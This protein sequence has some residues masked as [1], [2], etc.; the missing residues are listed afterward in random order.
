MNTKDPKSSKTPTAKTPA[1]MLED[2]VYSPTLAGNNRAL[3]GTNPL[4]AVPLT[5]MTYSAVSLL[6]LF[7]ATKTEAGKKVLEKTVSLILDDAEEKIQDI[8]PPP[9]P[10][11]AAPAAPLLK[12]E[13]KDPPPPPPT[14]DQEV[15]PDEAPPT[16]PTRDMSTAF[17]TTDRE[18]AGSGIGSSATG[19]PTGVGQPVA[20]TSSVVTVHEFSFNQMV[21]TTKPPD[22]TYPPIARAA[23]IRG[24]VNV[25]MIIGTD[26]VPVSAKAVSGPGML[27]EH[28]VAY[29]LK[30]RFRPATEDGR[31][32]QAKFVLGVNW[33]L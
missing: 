30:W 22:P 18:A 25:E 5:I 15:V 3:K 17:A 33:T 11:P 12:I 26:G 29:A 8:E 7:V 28:S 19:V 16:L 20:P 23:K 21:V 13:I 31:P 9:P 6:I 4:I 2:A 32:V 14:T 24:M 27:H 10:P 1:E